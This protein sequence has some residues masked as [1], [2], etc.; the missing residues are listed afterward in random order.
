MSEKIGTVELLRQRI[1]STES[2]DMC[3]DPGVY[4][5]R[6]SRD[7]YISLWL[8]GR[9]NDRQE[10]STERIGEGLFALRRGHDRPTGPDKAFPAGYW[11]PEQF[12][13]LLADPVSTEGDPEQRLRF[14]IQP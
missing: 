13:D 1:Y 7:G 4:E 10:A 14:T 2:G 3:V 12:A 8:T 11:S 6:R 5:V 9:L